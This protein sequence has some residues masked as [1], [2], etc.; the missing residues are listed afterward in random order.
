MPYLVP[1]VLSGE[2]TST[3]RL[4][5]DKDLQND[6]NLLLINKATGEEFAK[7]IITKIEEKKLKDLEESDFEGHEKFE[8]EEKMYEAYRSYYGD[9]VTPDTIIKMVDFKLV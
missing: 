2:K 5:D 4:F 1:L 7:A 9:K 3:W 8:S 6:D